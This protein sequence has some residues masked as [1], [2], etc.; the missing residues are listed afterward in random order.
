MFLND[1]YD[2]GVSGGES[3]HRDKEH[4]EF[5]YELTAETIRTIGE[6]SKKSL[7]ESIEDYDR[8]YQA[9]IFSRDS[10]TEADSFDSYTGG[11][12]TSWFVG[13]NFT[14]K[15][16]L[17]EGK[18]KFGLV[19]DN[20]ANRMGVQLCVGGGVSAA[21]SPVAISLLE[22]DPYS[23]GG[24]PDHLSFDSF[25]FPHGGE[26]WA[27]FGLGVSTDFYHESL[28]VGFGAEAGGGASVCFTQR[29]L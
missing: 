7:S 2:E 3:E 18:F 23:P 28:V 8:A 29:I 4:H 14:L 20:A 11:E 22:F 9:S 15:V 25:T 26:A 13:I 19:F 17:P 1:S 16:L 21:G 27:A 10:Y 24:V 5:V 12:R 6:L